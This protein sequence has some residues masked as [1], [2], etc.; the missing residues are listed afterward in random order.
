[1]SLLDHEFDTEY[2]L[3]LSAWGEGRFSESDLLYFQK[4]DAI[5]EE[6]LKKH[7]RYPGSISFLIKDSRGFGSE[8]GFTGIDTAFLEKLATLKELILPDTI[9]HIDL[10]ATLEKILRDNDTLIRGPFDSFA[11]SFAK[12]NSL[13][14]RPADF[15]FADFEDAR[16]HEFTE[17]TLIFKRNGGVE[18]KESSSSPGSSAGNTFGG[19]FTHSLPRDFY[20]IQTAEEIAEK[21]DE[22]TREAILSDGRLA[23]FIEKLKTHGFYRDKN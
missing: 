2:D 7:G 5:M 19:S 21:F 11:E 8:T 15:V 14:F 23:A 22:N 3:S 16:W 10:T 20:L 12:E 1:M 18:I 17:M 9:T 4:P 13:R 6:Y